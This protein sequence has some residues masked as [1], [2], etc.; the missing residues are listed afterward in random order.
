LGDYVYVEELPEAITKVAPSYPQGL[1]GVEGTVIVQALVGADGRVKDTIVQNSI[2]ALDEAAVEAVRQWV[3][4][5]AMSG[6]KPV[7][8][9]VAIPV[10]F[11]VR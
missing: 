9:W 7:A 8:V 4:K 10:K 5:P 6:G 3:F 1:R 2:P 11:S